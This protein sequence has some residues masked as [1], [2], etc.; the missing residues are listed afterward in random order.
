MSD[1]KE[2]ATNQDSFWG[3]EGKEMEWTEFESNSLFVVKSAE[4]DQKSGSRL[5]SDA[6]QEIRETKSAGR[7]RLLR[8]RSLEQR[9]H[10]GK[11]V[12][13]TAN[14][15]EKTICVIGSHKSHVFMQTQ[16]YQSLASDQSIITTSLYPW[17]IPMVRH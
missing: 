15:H 2:A 7:L 6:E 9:K 12:A 16:R 5:L 14:L 13:D 1:T 3:G 17:M 8:Q 10:I 11:I 4:E